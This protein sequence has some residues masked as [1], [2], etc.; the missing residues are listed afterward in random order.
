MV[1]LFPLRGERGP[2][3]VGRR[4]GDSDRHHHAER[5]PSGRATTLEVTGTGGTDEVHAADFRVAVGPKSSSRRSSSGMEVQGDSL[6]G[7]TGF[8]HGVGLS[9]WDAYKMAEEG[10]K[11][12]EI[13][14]AFFKEIEIE[15]L[16][17]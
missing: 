1:G 13:L 9:Q 8:G 3:G 4:S 16:W 14:K 6:V 17:D 7:G 2:G 11:A 10:K 12:E 5:G 15:R